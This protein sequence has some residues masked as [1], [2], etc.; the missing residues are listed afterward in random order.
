MKNGMLS[1]TRHDYCVRVASIT[2]YS[3]FV[4]MLNPKF[5]GD[6]FKWDNLYSMCSSNAKFQIEMSNI[7]WGRDLKLAQ[8]C[9]E[10]RVKYTLDKIFKDSNIKETT[11][12]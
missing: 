10:K 3:M 6:K 2:T 5:R 12:L 9:V 4:M 1:N 7:N 8:E 11:P